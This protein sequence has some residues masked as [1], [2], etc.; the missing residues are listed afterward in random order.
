MTAFQ[1]VD[2]LPPNSLVNFV[3]VLAKNN[4]GDAKLLLAVNQAILNKQKDLTTVDMSM[5]MSSLYELDRVT[6]ELD[7]VFRNYF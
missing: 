2:Q 3:G 6:V 5:L 4:F 7:M 1:E